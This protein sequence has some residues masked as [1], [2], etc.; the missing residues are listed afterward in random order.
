MYS[1]HARLEELEQ[2]I[3]ARNK[4]RPRPFL[5]VI[6]SVVETTISI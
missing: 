5:A 3:F 1:M 2:T 4:V 6:P